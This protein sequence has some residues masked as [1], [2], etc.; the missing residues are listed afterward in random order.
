MQRNTTAARLRKT[1]ESAT[2]ALN[3]GS[4]E[5]K[6]QQYTKHKEESEGKERRRGE[7][8]KKERT[9]HLLHRLSCTGAGVPSSSTPQT[10]HRLYRGCE[11]R[12]DSCYC[13]CCRQGNEESC[14]VAMGKQNSKLRPEMLQDLREN[15]EFSDHEL[16][17]WYKGFLKD[18]P[19]GTLN[20]EE[21]K[22]IYA[23]FFPYGDASKFAEHVFR[24]F[25]TN[26]RWDDRLPGV[27]HRL[28]RDVTGESWSRN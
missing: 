9:E 11:R 26:W 19:S 2:T 27:H 22:K 5:G 13:H 20:V 3:P 15:T 8:Q 14:P 4:E 25:D 24:T 21:F 18:C 1:R 10:L 6:C 16:Q 17:E 23:N 28:E 12:P 7:H